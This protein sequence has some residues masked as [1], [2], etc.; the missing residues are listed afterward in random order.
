MKY[1]VFLEVLSFFL[2]QA[3]FPPVLLCNSADLGSILNREV[4]MMVTLNRPFFE[5][6]EIFMLNHEF[7]VLYW[8]CQSF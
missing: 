4:S 3:T 1:C 2:K 8:D 7:F 5:L 6:I